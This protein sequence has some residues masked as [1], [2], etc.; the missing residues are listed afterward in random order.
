M[1]QELANADVNDGLS[2]G[3][4]I[5]SCKGLTLDERR[6]CCRESSLPFDVAILN[7]TGELNVGNIIRTASL[8]GADRVHILGRRKYDKRGT[9]GAENYI[10]VRRIDLMK[11]DLNIDVE[12]VRDYFDIKQLFPIFVEQ[13]EH[14]Q[15]LSM[16]AM[17]ATTVA[18][19]Q[20]KQPC[21]VFGNE[22]RGIPT[23]LIDLFSPSER[24][25]IQLNQLGVIRS[26]NVGS[27]AAI[28]LYEAMRYYGR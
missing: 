7:V 25:I 15:P 5:D 9:V 6:E 22:G 8:C 18:F 10:E 12:S 11:D 2:A 24:V 20:M 23:E 21:F 28:V 19:S 26:F 17:L 3:N 1:Y 14:A 27:T 16:L 13:H 4:V